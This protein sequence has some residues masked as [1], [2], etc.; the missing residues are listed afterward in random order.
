MIIDD[1]SEVKKKISLSFSSTSL[2]LSIIKK[3]SNKN[4][5][6]FSD[7]YEYLN[8]LKNEIKSIDC[9][10][11][12]IIFRD[13]DCD[14]FSNLS[15]TRSILSKR[16]EVF[17]ELIF[18]ENKNTIFLI[19]IRSILHKVVPLKEINQKRLV[20]N[21]DKKCTYEILIKY[22]NE[23]MYERVEFVR[24]KGE[25]A[26]R[27][28]IIDVFTPNEKNPARISFEFDNVESL[29]LFDVENQ[30]SFKKIFEYHLFVASEILF[31]DSSIKNFR[32][33]FRKLKLTGKEE[34]YKSISNKI[35]LP[36]SD[37]FYPI[38][39]KQFDSIIAYLSDVLIFI[40][41]DFFESYENEYKKMIYEFDAINNL[42]SKETNFLQKKNELQSLLSKQNVFFLY[43]YFVK[44]AEFYNFFNNEILFK[45]KIKNF[46][47]II[48]SSEQ[49]KKII[50]CTQS[51]INKKKI[52]GFLNNKKKKFYDIK[53]FNFE[54]LKK[55]NA[56][57]F[58]T[59]LSITS[60][61][62]IKIYGFDII[63]L[64][65]YQLFEKVTKKVTQSKNSDDNLINEFSE[66][67]LGDLV[68]HM[69]H[70]IGKF[71]GIRNSDI[72]GYSQDFLELL[73]Y[74]NDKLL[75]PIEN[76]ELI[77]RYGYIEK[78]ITLD[79]LGLQNWQN[80]KALIKKKI[81]DIAYELVKTAA[82]RKLIK[83][84][85]I[86]FNNL[87][88]EKFSSFFEFTE[89]S[90]Q[91]K[92]IQQ[93]ENDLVSGNPMDRLICGDVGF[94]KT[95]IAMRAAFIA[96]SAGYQV[97]MICPKVLLVNQHYETFKKRFYG[98]NY[99]ISKISRL[100]SH[101]KKKEIIDSIYSGSVDIIIGSHALLSNKIKFKK[102]GLIIV[103]EEQSFGVQQKEKLK[104]IKPN[105]HILTLS[106]TPIPRTLQSSFLKIRE[107]SLIK[108]PPINRLN[109]KTFLMIYDDQFLK[110]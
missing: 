95:E 41:N 5:V 25:F 24:N 74:N 107:I 42:I 12:V 66:L 65:D 13:F 89:T 88:Y 38:L 34:Y 105:S 97:A 87:E 8:R 54:Y 98:F 1:I 109:V 108:T 48:K 60:S 28:D 47:F 11:K 15:P 79:K 63:F 64:S 37:Q 26:I 50:F 51:N 43:N 68:V 81:K 46:D 84:D 3:K 57:F 73:Y 53:N 19:S 103:D 16:I 104:K 78:N 71:N 35:L 80:R 56:N 106:A 72:N 20:V 83:A 93:I 18:S 96:V 9:K 99:K 70:G 69:D 45:N 52:I 21:T 40:Q 2:F 101:T 59:N 4:I 33:T 44:G 86:L 76:L 102:L 77:T 17:Y 91:I 22:L 36:G 61:F 29:N 94:G 62:S 31:N 7:N 6:Y 92:A 27:G 49:K 30:K 110:K 90:D 39:F 82:R 85:K 14:F 100:E 58:L 75:I 32:Q 67:L 55:N 10:I 23:N